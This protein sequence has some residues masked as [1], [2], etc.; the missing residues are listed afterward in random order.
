MADA[1]WTARHHHLLGDALKD[2]LDSQPK[3][4]TKQ[5]FY[6]RVAAQ[7]KA[8]GGGDR[9]WKE[10]LQHCGHVRTAELD[11]REFVKRECSQRPGLAKK[12]VAVRSESKVGSEDEH[13]LAPQIEDERTEAVLSGPTG[14][15]DLGV[16]L[17]SEQVYRVEVVMWTGNLE[18]TKYDP[19]NPETARPAIRKLVEDTLL[20]QRTHF[21]QNVSNPTYQPRKV[22]TPEQLSR[23]VRVWTIARLYDSVGLQTLEYCE[24]PTSVEVK[25]AGW[26]EGAWEVE[27][28]AAADGGAKRKR[29][30]SAIDVGEDVE[31]LRAAKRR[32]LSSG[33]AAVLPSPGQSVDEWTCEG[34]PL[35]FALNVCERYW[36]AVRHPIWPEYRGRV[37]G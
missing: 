19:F 32:A 28:P 7:L 24:R 31:T 4:Q 17:P 27:S 25:W 13:R 11:E 22:S 37:T 9:P 6:S 21:E 14:R 12:A 20:Y 3:A 16:Q 15:Q 35:A 2:T 8:L 34:V 23:A 26:P 10:V 1:P 18:Y 36:S 5:G 30:D 33:P 29:L